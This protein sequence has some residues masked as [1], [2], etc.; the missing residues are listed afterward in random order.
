MKLFT[1]HQI[2]EIDQ[3]TM[4]LEPI[5]SIDLMER[6][7]MKVADWLLRNIDGDC[8]LWFFAG[9]GNN[10]GDGYVLAEC[11]RALGQSGVGLQQLRDAGVVDHV[12]QAVAAHQVDVA[13]LHLVLH[14]HL[15][16]RI[17]VKPALWLG[18]GVHQREADVAA[19]RQLQGRHSAEH[20]AI[21][22]YA[23]RAALVHRDDLVM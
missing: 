20:E 16:D 17:L 14:E 13:G 3:L 23:G 11:L 1:C 15:Y 12:R 2:S 19:C 6:A 9:P 10:G 21:L 18:A 4:Q 5:A 7:S 8:P 22:G